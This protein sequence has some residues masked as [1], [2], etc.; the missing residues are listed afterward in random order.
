MQ[1]LLYTAGVVGPA[2]GAGA[3]LGGWFVG[4]AVLPVCGDFQR[5]W[6][7]SA[8]T[9]HRA[10]PLLEWPTLGMPWGTVRSNTASAA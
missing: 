1:T 8:T 9:V 3:G 5:R 10:K 2:L 7:H 6:Q 4:V